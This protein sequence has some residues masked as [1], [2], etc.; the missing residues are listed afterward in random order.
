[1][2]APTDTTPL[3]PPGPLLQFLGACLQPNSTLLVSEFMAGGDLR[4]ALSRNRP[5]FLWAGGQG[6]SL[7][8]DIARGLHSLHARHIV[9]F[10][11]KSSSECGAVGSL[12]TWSLACAGL[13]GG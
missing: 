9:H 10:D 1:M 6:R 5:A 13:A 12:N 3:S 2:P 11:L 8:M 4:A 7:G